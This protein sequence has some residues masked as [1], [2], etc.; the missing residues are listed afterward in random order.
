MKLAELSGLVISVATA[1][2]FGA[3]IYVSPSGNDGTGDG[4]IGAPYATL[5][6]ARD[7]ATSG[8]NVYLR[9]GTYYL[10]ASVVFGVSNSGTAGAPIIYQSYPGEKAIISGGILLPS[11]TAWSAVTL[12]GVTVQHTTITANLHVDQLF[13]NGKL[14]ILARYPNYT[15]GAVL[16]GNAAD[17]QTKALAGANPAEGPGYIRGIHS[18]QWGG[19]DYY[20]TSKTATQWVGDNNRGGGMNTQMM[21]EN[22][23][24]FLD[25]AGE[26]F[27]R[28]ST[29]E[30]WFY[31]PAGAN[32]STSTIELASISQLLRFVG[33][34]GTSA[35]SVKY[36]TFRNVTFTHAY[37]SLFD[38]TGQ[39]YELVTGSDWGICRKGAVFMQNAEN[40]RIDS[41]TF[42]H[43]GGNGV[44]MSAYNNHNVVS[45][46]D[47][48]GTGANCVVMM[49]L[50]SSIRCPNYWNGGNLANPACSDVTPGPLTQDYPRCCVVYNNLM[51]TFG[52]FEKQ[53]AGVAFSATELDTVRH[54]S[55]CHCPRAGINFCDGCWGGTVV[56]Y[57]WVYDVV[58][59]T[60]DHGPLNAWGRD[61]NE[62][63]GSN[64]AA[65]T[66]YDSRNSTKVRMNR[67]EAPAGMFGIDLDDQASNY[68]Q[69]K[70]LILGAG[71]KFQWT[72]ADTAINNISTAT[73]NGNVQFHGTWGSAS[74]PSYHYGARNIIYAT[75]TCVYQFC[76]GAN[77]S[78]MT[79]TQMKWDSNMVY[80][81]AG[82]PNCS[83]WN[84]CGTGNYTF[85]TWQGAGMDA[86]SSVG[87][88]TFT[89]TA[90]TWTGRTPAYLP[91][92]NYN[93]TSTVALN[94]LHFQT[95]AMDSFGIITSVG[96]GVKE[97]FTGRTEMS[98]LGKAVSVYYS[99][100]RLTVSYGGSYHVSITSV[101]GRTLA[102]FNGKDRSSFA[103]D[104]MRFGS[105]LFF[106]VVN[107][108]NGLVSKRFLV[109]K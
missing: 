18:S 101:A 84:S 47:F 5:T 2:V 72:R 24:E 100:R 74:Q 42:D 85:A 70:N 75:S 27:Y 50:R 8:T 108:K 61:R 97:P 13:L 54:N 109:S 80:S 4:S 46:C 86:H 45:G 64:N 89:N 96:V 33:S 16:N 90:Q 37:R 60:S 63:Y 55:I 32:L 17:A 62:I 59:E 44:F 10:T 29:G 93:P 43:V 23:I 57:N 14:Q 20:I 49:G 22:V 88:P 12:N 51:D 58:R 41:C 67:F 31:P 103:L 91:V 56:D 95:F 38:S 77:P 79:G 68:F 99:A 98:D 39:F 26:W 1:V 19:N 34:G 107:T 106:A 36:I 21:A 30:L 52:V 48:E 104:A 66:F 28:K 71:F 9:R 40:I 35:N 6:K 94:T 102:T 76:C 83:D 25:A 78:Y 3:D 53:V 81:T 11:S 73:N 82:T 87:N 69:E 7:M 15:A 92:G 105:G 65:A